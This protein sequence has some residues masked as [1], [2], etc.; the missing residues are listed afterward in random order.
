L[1]FGVTDTPPRKIVGSQYCL[2]PPGLERKK[3]Q[4]AQL[5]NHQITFT[6]I[7]VVDTKDGRVIIFEI[8]P[9]T[10]GV[11]TTW[12]GYAYGR[13]RDSIGPL[14][15]HKIE[16]I[17][18]QGPIPDWSARICEG[19]TIDDLDPEAIAFARKEYQKK[20]SELAG[21][22]DSWSEVEFLNR[23][24][25]CIEGKITNAAIILLGKGTAEHH[26]SPALAQITWVL[27]DASGVERDYVHFG[28]PIILAVNKVFAKIRNLNYRYLSDETLFPL[29]I[30]QYEPWVIRETLHNCI[31]HQDYLQ[32]ARI[33]VVESEDS[34]LFTNRGEFIPGSIESLIISEAPPDHY[35]N[36]FLAQAMV[37]L[38]MIDTIGSGIKRMFRYQRDRNFPLPDFDL[39]EPGKVSVRIIGKII[40][41]R[42]TRMLIRRK[43]LSLMDVIALDKVQK[44]YKLSDAEFHSLKTKKLIEG[45]RPNLYVSEKVAAETDT[46]ADYIRK[47]SF[48]KVHFKDMIIE[49]LKRYHEADRAEIDKLLLN[50]V[51]DAL[52]YEQKREFVKNLLQEMRREGTIRTTGG[53]TNAAKWI[54]ST[55]RKEGE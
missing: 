42:Y 20:F 32:G 8:P 16:R 11:P 49:Y 43:D 44:S 53:R 48:D 3:Q 7:T 35:R 38:N 13:I 24:K 26:L 47:R 14:P 39:S 2:T 17:R 50:K 46:R 10:R 54:L 15:L 9:S 29:E 6:S 30:Y 19:S 22:V 1:I 18:S 27:K 37:N 21:E 33:S 23:A 40:D 12:R 52:N 25:L 51:S 45:R 55:R 41:P 4:I 31:A 5:T 34:I 36:P 28:P